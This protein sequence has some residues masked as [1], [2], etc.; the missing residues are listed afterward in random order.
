MSERTGAKI[1]IRGKGASRDGGPSTTGHTDDED[2][3]H[4]CLEG[5]DEAVTK[6]SK[7]VEELLFNP[8]MAQ[9]LKSQQLGFPLPMAPDAYGPGGSESVEMKVPNNMVGLIIGKGG[10]NIARIQ[11]TL[12]V[13]A[14][15]AKETDMGP[16]ET[17][18]SVILT[19]IPANVLEAKQRIEDMIA[20]Q[21]AKM[22]GAG[23]GGAGENRFLGRDNNSRELDTA[24]VVKLPVPNDKVGIIIGK[25][26]STIKG[27]QDRTRA[28]VQIPSGPDEG[29]PNVRT[30][31]IGADT[32]ECVDAAQMEIFT[33]LQQHQQQTAGQSS[34]GTIVIVPND[35]VGAIIGRGGLTV[36]EIQSRHN[37]RV[38]V[39]QAADVGS[40]PPT[41]T[42]T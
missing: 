4:V 32:K 19:G 34:A 39:P 24:F 16:G 26:G 31:S 22:A 13:H 17:E 28:N 29:D 30:I 5:S 10:E 35:R 41:R 18:R 12:G 6:A 38:Q 14:Q 33:C 27:I 42:I 7:E 36:R 23:A 21:L 15:I 8:E 3:L 25:G 9:R 11:Q 40:M 20:G 37:V 2:E 1:I